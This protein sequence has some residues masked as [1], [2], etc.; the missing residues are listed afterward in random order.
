MYICDFSNGLEMEN[1]VT[2]Y[3]P[4]NIILRHGQL[5]LFFFS[6]KTKI[7]HIFSEILYPKFFIFNLI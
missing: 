7:G 5:I 4:L 6:E 1:S 2:L 3:V